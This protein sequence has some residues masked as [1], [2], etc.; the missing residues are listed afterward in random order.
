MKVICERGYYKF[1]PETANDVAVFENMTGRALV[2]VGNYYTFAKLAELPN[3]SIEG[4]MYGGIVSKKNYAGRVEDVFYQN[5]LK[6]N[7]ADDTI[8]SNDKLAV[9]GER[10]DNYIWVVSGIPQAYG[11][12]SDKTVVSGFRGFVDVMYNYT[13]ITGWENADF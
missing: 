12:L 6:Y 4:Q 11:Q 2:A 8:E 7:I 5:K 3:F 1:F 13:A 10:V 9:I